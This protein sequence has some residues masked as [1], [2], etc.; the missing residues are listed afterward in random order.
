MTDPAS[1]SPYRVLA[2]RFRPQTFADLIG[3]QVLVRTLTNAILAGR[4]PHAFVLTGVRGVGKTS[5]ARI[6]AKA[7]NCTARGDAPTTEPCGTCASCIAI[8]EDRHVDVLEMDAASHTGVDDI[9]DLIDGVRYAPVS[10]RFKVYIIDEV[11]MLSRNAFNA[12]LKTLEEPPPR[13]L[14]VF[15]TTEVRKIPVTV[16][17]RCMRFDLR[18]VEIPDLVAHFSRIAQA[19]GID[20]EAAALA[21][22]ARAAEGSVRDG[23]SLLDQAA[24]LSGDRVTEAAVRDMLGL[25]DRG[26]VYDLLEK[27]L[28][29]DVAAAL[30]LLRELNAAGAEPAVVLE[31]L[32]ALVHWLTRLKVAE[33]A[34]GDETMPEE[35]RARGRDLAA[36][37]SMPVLTRAWQ[38]LLKGLGEVRSAPA[39][40]MAL[41]MVIIRFGYAAELPPPAEVIREL[42]RDDGAA[43]ASPPAPRTSPSRPMAASAPAG[44]VVARRAPAARPAAEPAT[45]HP[46]TDP[47]PRAEAVPGPADFPAVIALVRQQREPILETQLRNNVHL[48]DFTPGHIALRLD[49]KVASDL[50]SRLAAVLGTATG[51]RW[52]VSVSNEPGAPTLEEQARQAQQDRLDAVARDPVVR[53]VLDTFPGAE[54]RDIRELTDGSTPPDADPDDLTFDNGYDPFD[55]LDEE[56]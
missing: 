37:L 40:A 48:V 21:L 44:A 38:M 33:T 9:R 20:A 13:V 25:A 32:L 50:P 3:Q 49:G 41:D 2:R 35:E 22:I 8:A 19:E 24:T 23:L 54:I 47:V 39:P 29:G 11:H 14:F 7:V 26:R 43:P 53:R 34:I 42:T 46:V 1:S 27:V 45:D 6:I 16:L 30:H 31:D 28:A 56:D 5:T 4:L 15:A 36:R 12:L 10:G 51:R 52:V 55:P 18:R 17:S